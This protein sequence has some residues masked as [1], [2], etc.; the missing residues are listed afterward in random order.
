MYSP[1]APP[2]GSLYAASDFEYIELTNTGVNPVN[3][4]GV[5]FSEGID[6]TFGATTLPAGG[7]VVLAHNP[8]AFAS[9]YGAGI[10]TVGPYNGSLDNG[11]EN[12]RLL[13][14]NN[15]TIADIT[16]SNEWYPITDGQGFSLV[17]VDLNADRATLDQ[18]EASR[19]SEF[20][21]GNP[22]A[23]DAVLKPGSIVI[24][25]VLT[26]TTQALGDWIELYNTTNAPINIG[27][28]YLS[29]DV[30]ADQVPHSGGHDHCG[31]R[32]RRI[33]AIGRLR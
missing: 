8:A 1:T 26:N 7:R 19:P 27:G 12:L 2:L 30:S 28:W 23:A 32:I 33:H 9:R 6:Y 4:Q 10:A 24:N 15:E 16:Y 13:D 14:A 20:T 25:E 21:G 3:L 31:R 5:H 11:G 29:N 17:A 22:A 18:K